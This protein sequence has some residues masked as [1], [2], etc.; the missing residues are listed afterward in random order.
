MRIRHC[1]WRLFGERA[2]QF[3]IRLKTR[4]PTPT[5]RGWLYLVFESP[6]HAAEFAVRL[7]TALRQIDW[8][9]LGLSPDTSARI[10]L[11]TGPV[12]RTFDP[13]M[14]KKTFSGTHVNRTAR[15]EPI[16]RPGHIFCTEA[17]AASLAA[18]ECGPFS[19]HY[20]GVMPLAKQ[21]GEARLYRLRST[22]D[23]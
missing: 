15:L 19:C 8:P 20:I 3:S 18:N 10:G 7:Q 21:F 11:H 4:L 14:G 17:F 6:R 13:V 2:R 12:F 9:A 23:D 22:I 5:R 1:S 16:V